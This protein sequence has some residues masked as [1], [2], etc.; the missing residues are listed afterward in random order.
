MLLCNAPSQLFVKEG[1]PTESAIRHQREVG[2]FSHAL[3]ARAFI[4]P[5]G[6]ATGDSVK[7]EY[8]LA[9]MTRR[10]I[11][12]GHQAPTNALPS[13][14]AAYQHLRNISAMWLIFRRG[15]NQ[16]YSADDLAFSVFGNEKYPL[17]V[18]H[19]VG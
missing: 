9:G 16:L 11:Y 1:R 6:V 13:R 4:K 2:Y 3:P 5:R 14:V 10:F 15:S 12:R 8:R 7:Y 19:P 18:H 17:V